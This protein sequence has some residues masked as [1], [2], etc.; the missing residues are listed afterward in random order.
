MTFIDYIFSCS[1]RSLVVFVLLDL[2]LY[3]RSMFVL[4]SFFFWSLCC[5]FFDIRILI[6]P[7]VSSKSSFV[8]ITMCIWLTFGEI[9]LCSFYCQLIVDPALFYFNSQIFVCSIPIYLY[10]YSI[11]VERVRWI[12]SETLWTRLFSS[13]FRKFVSYFGLLDI[14]R[15]H[16]MCIHVMEFI[17]K[18]RHAH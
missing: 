10:W 15:Y 8:N 9:V 11:H 16:T 1:P 13:L 12:S 3:C 7:L 14:V 5:L 4:L 2:K 17:P 18:M 6:T